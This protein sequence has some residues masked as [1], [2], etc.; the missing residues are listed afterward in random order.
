MR[1]YRKLNTVLR[2]IDNIKKLYKVSKKKN[3]KDKK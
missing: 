3:K 1:F 2:T